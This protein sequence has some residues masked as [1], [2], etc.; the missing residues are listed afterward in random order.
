VSWS[1]HFEIP[2][3]EVEFGILGG[4]PFTPEYLL[5]SPSLSLM[6]LR[7]LTTKFPRSATILNA[8]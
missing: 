8:L 6:H 4:M 3:I 7:Q 2:L 5:K 1:L